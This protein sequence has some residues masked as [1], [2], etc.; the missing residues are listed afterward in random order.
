MSAEGT[1]WQGRTGGGSFGI[2]AVSF[3]V[4]NF[5]ASFV[6]FFMAFSIPFYV[7]SKNG[8]RRSVYRFYRR[9]L[10]YGRWKAV[11]AMWG[12][13]YTFGKVVV[14]KFASYG[15]VTGGYVL[16][17]DDRAAR[18]QREIHESAEGAVIVSAHVG[19]LEAL[20]MLFSQHDKECYCTVYGGESPEILKRRAE[21]LKANH[22][23]LVPVGDDAG[24]VFELGKAIEEGGVIL[25]MSDRMTEGARGVWCRLFGMEAE[26][27]AGAF[28]LSV[29]MDIPLYTAFVMR[30]GHCRYG[31]IWEK[32]ELQDA[33]APEKERMAARAQEYCRRLEGVV[34]K[35]PLQWFNFYD[36][37][38]EE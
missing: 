9:R 8:G 36:F 10:G 18:V 20:G 31:I 2:R 11:A 26:I 28:A 17:M 16:E 4:K 29:R 30:T 37:W 23:H 21:A 34:G 3:L 5:G 6:Y 27:P 33:D 12:C 15:G 13:Y 24:Y 7:F 22:I 38:K 32:L 1:R 25:T 19:N 14:D 35:Y